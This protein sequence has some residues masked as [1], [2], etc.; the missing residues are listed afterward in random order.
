MTQTGVR[1]LVGKDNNENHKETIAKIDSRA[2]QLRLA[3]KTVLIDDGHGGMA[4]SS[5]Q[6][7]YVI[8]TGKNIMWSD[9]GLADSGWFD[10]DEQD[11][12][13]KI[14]NGLRQLGIT[15]V[16]DPS[17]PDAY[18]VVEDADFPIDMWT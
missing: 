12:H 6:F 16:Q 4:D 7:G 13:E 18:D 17:H 11:D 14:Q 10:E 9:L 2:G 15:H 1:R 3:K 8:E 5:P